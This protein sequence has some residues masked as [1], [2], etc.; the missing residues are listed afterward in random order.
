MLAL[1]GPCWVLTLYQTS[2]CLG[3]YSACHASLCAFS[4]LTHRVCGCQTL[5]PMSPVVRYQ[6]RRYFL[7]AP[8][9]HLAVSYTHLRAHETEADL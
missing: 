6:A 4:G 3:W 5:P 9:T 8:T 2:P 1:D 7:C